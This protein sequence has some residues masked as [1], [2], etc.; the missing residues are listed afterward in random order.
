MLINDDEFY[1][2]ANEL[3]LIASDTAKLSDIADHQST[4]N[5]FVTTGKVKRVT[6]S[7]GCFGMT[8]DA[9]IS[10]GG[11]SNIHPSISVPLQTKDLGQHV[12]ACLDRFL[13]VTQRVVQPHATL[14]TRLQLP[15]EV[16]RTRWVK[17]DQDDLK[18]LGLADMIGD[19]QAHFLEC[20]LPGDL[21]PQRHRR[22][23]RIG[24]DDA[25][26]AGSTGES[27]QGRAFE[28]TLADGTPVPLM[29]TSSA[30]FLSVS[31]RRVAEVSPSGMSLESFVGRLF[32]YFRDAPK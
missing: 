13:L 11:C 2:K 16:P 28:A 6:R 27:Q 25:Q 14:P 23:R 1:N 9:V 3:N 7:A 24:D 19:P 5:L 15:P 26:D 22:L 17:L 18:H 10:A 30:V 20:P 31:N 8:S 12:A 21:P 4:L 32:A 29:V